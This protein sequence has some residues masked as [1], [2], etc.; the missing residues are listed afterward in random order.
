MI[1]EEWLAIAISILLPVLFCIVN[2]LP[3]VL[4]FGKPPLDAKATTFV[5]QI[6]DDEFFIHRIEGL[7]KV[8]RIHRA[9]QC[10]VFSFPPKCP[11][12][13]SASVRTLQREDD[14]L[15]LVSAIL[16]KLLVKRNKIFEWFFRSIVVL[17]ADKQ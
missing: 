13:V 1:A 6:F 16:V 17:T 4:R 10:P 11:L 5:Y 7:A 15:H 12:R 9:V 2:E 8:G 3:L 14:M